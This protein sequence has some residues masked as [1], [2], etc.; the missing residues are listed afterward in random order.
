MFGFACN[1]TETLMPM[2]IHYAH[3]LVKRMAD[4]RKDGTLP[5]LRPDSK[6]QVTV[7]YE[8]G[9]PQRIHTVLISTQHAPTTQFIR[10]PENFRRSPLPIHKIVPGLA[11]PSH[12]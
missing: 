2:P 9:Q 3:K 11:A 8:Y 6:S 10:D 4:I 5:W 12:A 1:E 7:E